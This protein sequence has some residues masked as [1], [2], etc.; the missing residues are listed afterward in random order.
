MLTCR[1]VTERA[2]DYVDG[3]LGFWSRMD[4]RMHL[5]ACKY[6]RG[7]VKQMRTVVGLVG[8]YR[9]IPPS[10][11]TEQE[12][13]D[14]FRKHS[15]SAPKMVP[16]RTDPGRNE[17]D[18]IAKGVIAGFVATVV[19]SALMLMKSAMGLM[20]ELDVIAMLGGMMGT[21]AFMGWMAHF[22]IGSILWGGFFAVVAPNLP[23]RSLWLKGMTF[24]VGAWILMMVAVMP[25]AGAGPFGAN[26]GMAAPV[27][28]LMLHVIFGAVLG[29][30]YAALQ[31]REGGHKYAH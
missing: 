16:R 28:T 9:D 3:N 22:V 25:M 27:M 8:E 18:G 20:P 14:A 24:G 10:E 1:E 26:L 2:N 21:G 13:L 6:C 7:F 19:L 23:G 30:V 4:V 12:L 29:S 15:N 31:H 17:M 5:L 11:E